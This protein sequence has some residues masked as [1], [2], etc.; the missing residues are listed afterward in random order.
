MPSPFLGVIPTETLPS[1]DRFATTNAFLTS[2]ATALKQAIKNNPG[3]ALLISASMGA[4]LA[5]LIKRR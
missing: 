5:C 3:M 4:V 2:T 1:E